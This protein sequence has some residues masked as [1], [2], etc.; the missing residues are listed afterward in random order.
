[1]QVA[2]R[3]SAATRHSPLVQVDEVANTCCEINVEEGCVRGLPPFALLALEAPSRAPRT[4]G[5]S[6]P[7]RC[8]RCSAGEPAWGKDPP[9]V[10][11]AAPVA[12][13]VDVERVL[14]QQVGV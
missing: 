1:M 11:P 3:R 12:E 7:P 10:A 2:T 13:E 4:R 6:S 9:Y 14:G 8:V 5:S